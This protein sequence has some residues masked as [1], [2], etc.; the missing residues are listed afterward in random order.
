MKHPKFP[1]KSIPE[2]E[3]QLFHKLIDCGVLLIKGSWF[4]GEKD[5]EVGKLFFR[6]TY[7][8][9]PAERIE[10]AMQRFGLSVEHD[11]TAS[12]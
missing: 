10:E 9:A 1:K 2:I 6:A 12:D 3:D 7:A 11:F 5:Q 8:A 4:C